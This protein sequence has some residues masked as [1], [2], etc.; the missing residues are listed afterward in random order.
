MPLYNSLLIALNSS[1]YYPFIL[2]SYFPSLAH[3]NFQGYHATS[4]LLLGSALTINPY[5]EIV[6]ILPIS[7]F[8]RWIWS[9]LPR[10]YQINY[11]W[12][13]SIWTIPCQ[14]I[15]IGYLL[16]SNVYLNYLFLNARNKYMK[17]YLVIQSFINF[18]DSLILLL[19]SRMQL[20]IPCITDNFFLGFIKV[21][22]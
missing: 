21:I 8:I 7:P 17:L 11:I 16:F 19:F 15:R 1:Y 18:L 2:F 4:T 6:Y 22:E 9:Q 5:L 13:Y 3:Y 10:A 12:A 20:I 14:C